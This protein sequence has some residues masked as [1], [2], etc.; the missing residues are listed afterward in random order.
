MPRIDIPVVD[1][2]HSLGDAIMRLKKS[3]CSIVAVRDERELKI[4]PV[5]Q[6]MQSRAHGKESVGDVRAHTIFR[7]R[8]KFDESTQPALRTFAIGRKAARAGLRVMSLG[9]ETATIMVGGGLAGIASTAPRCYC[10]NPKLRPPHSYLPEEA[11]R[12]DRM[13]FDGY[14]IVCP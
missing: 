12:K 6:L 11:E 8:G 13:C 4:I 14:E 9:A 2:S 10:M 7:S 1:A 3:E 5:W